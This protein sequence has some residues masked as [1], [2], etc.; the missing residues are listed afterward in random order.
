MGDERHEQWARALADVLQPMR[1]AGQELR[2]GLRQAGAE[3]RE[4]WPRLSA[5]AGREL[6]AAGQ[7]LQSLAGE[8][9]LKELA[10]EVSDDLRAAGRDLQ[11]ALGELQ[12]TWTQETPPAPDRAESSDQAPDA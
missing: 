11:Q 1:A 2:R 5:E 12:R 10:A 3:L 6:R 7:E 8:L 4:E 9:R